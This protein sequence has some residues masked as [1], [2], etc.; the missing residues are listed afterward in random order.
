[1]KN[2]QKLVNLNSL[3]KSFPCKMKFLTKEYSESF[4]GNNLELFFSKLNFLYVE[5]DHI[6]C[7]SASNFSPH[8]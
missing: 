6:E 2:N 8:P 1:M 3:N 7:K 5:Q 4:R